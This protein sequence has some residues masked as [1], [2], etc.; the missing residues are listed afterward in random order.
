MVDTN[1]ERSGSLVESHKGYDPRTLFF[2]FVVAGL[3]LA[4]AGGLAYQQLF[5]TDEYHERERQQNQRRILIP[6]P[7]GNIYDREGRLLV[8]NRPRFAV[9][10]HLDELR[11]EFRREYIKVRKS[12]RE[13][14]D[15]DI[16]N[17][18]QMA[19]IARY[20]VVQSYLDQVNAATGRSEKVNAADLNRH[21]HGELLLPFTLLNDLSSEEYAKFIEQ[22]PVKSPLQIIAS[23]TRYYPYGSAA[24]H[25]LGYV[26]TND[27]IYSEDEYTGDN[28]AI[29]NEKNTFKMRG[30]IG[31]LGIE[32]E[33]D[34]LLQGETGGI[35]Y[36]VDPAGYRVDPPIH[37]RVP[38]QGKNITT[39]L[40]ID[41]QLVAEKQLATDD[42][43]GAAVALDVNTGE[44][45]VLAGKPDYD[46]NQ[47]SPKISTVA[48][49]SWQEK[50]SQFNLPVS[51]LS[52]PGSTFKILVSIA[53]MR[54]G[55]L[56][57][58]NDTTECTGYLKIGNTLKGCDN[59]EARHGVL[60][61]R[62]AIAQS[63]DIFFYHYGMQITSEV[64][65]AE[66]RR[67]HL[68]K[69][70]GI[71]LPGETHQMI[72]PDPAWKKAKRGEGW[73]PGDTANMAIGQGFVWLTPLQMAC[74]TASVAR[75]ETFTQ[76]TLE[77]HIER[78][79]QHTEPIGLSPSQYSAL[80]DGMEGCVTHGTAKILSQPKPMLPG[81]RIAGKTGTAQLPEKLNMAWFICFAP[82][83]KPEIA[84]AVAVQS[85]TPGEN[86][87]GGRYAAPIAVDILKKYF[88]KK[89]AALM[90][91]TPTT[92][93]PAVSPVR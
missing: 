53:G 20:S 72:I 87:A 29:F 77:H 16:P 69:P 1:T 63:C 12:Y 22:L 81:I 46:L 80:I 62:E 48:W 30:T 39:S 75:N 60:A 3:L 92:P 71:E 5:K 73:V 38:S 59:G 84:I 43:I 85:D 86:F 78:R 10:I 93:K 15:K 19:Q 47:T 40:D 13:L 65:A 17:A 42:L 70:T 50:K 7:R 9:T 74:F 56:S 11:K 51:G 49:A 54:S 25:V 23:S 52:P 76:P 82:R 32:S 88:E 27:D 57:T 21:F 26:T 31:K 28:L 91:A 68:D 45:L 89:R 36:R 55:A 58:D 8:G 41:L 44:V 33:Y 61:L 14:G 6:G 64:I 66:A 37:R 18:N 34:N 35:V 4:L 83:E 90:P 2:Y 67:F 79:T 24:S